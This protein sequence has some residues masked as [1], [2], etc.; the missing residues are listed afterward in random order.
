MTECGLLMPLEI[1]K[2][3]SED[4]NQ[5]DSKD[6]IPKIISRE[7]ENVSPQR[8]S[9][10][11]TTDEESDFPISTDAD[12]NVN[13]LAKEASVALPPI[14]TVKCGTLT[15][16]MVTKLFT[17]PGIHQNCILIDGETEYISP[18]E[19]T[20]RA[21]KDKQKDWKGSIRIG[22]SNL[23]TL[24]EMRS[25][26]F[27]DHPN[28]CSAK[29]QSRN[30]IT[31]K[32][33]TAD[34]SG[35]RRSST[36]KLIPQNMFSHIP[37]VFPNTSS[38]LFT[39]PKKEP[40]LPEGQ[41]TL[42]TLFK[43]PTFSRFVAISQNMKNNNFSTPSTTQTPLPMFQTS[44][45]KEESMDDMT[46]QLLQ[47]QQQQRV[48]STLLQTVPPQPSTFWN[49]ENRYQGKMEQNPQEVLAEM[50]SAGLGDNIIDMI[51]NKINNMRDKIKG[52]PNCPNILL[53]MLCSLNAADTFCNTLQAVE[54]IQAEITKEEQLLMKSQ[55][56]VHRLSS[57]YSS[58]EDEVPGRKRSLDIVDLIN[59]PQAKRPSLTTSMLEDGPEPPVVQ[60]LLTPIKPMVQIPKPIS[61]QEMLMNIAS[62]MGSTIERNQC[63]SGPANGRA[64]DSHCPIRYSILIFIFMITIIRIP[65]LFILCISKMLHLSRNVQF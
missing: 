26:D 28:Q 23:R 46:T 45:I 30:Y 5:E 22:K 29:C 65:F 24:M 13:M 8:R 64:P 48:T 60:H 32:D 6:L 56:Q 11:E 50:I 52:I 14:I 3:I 47:Q 2:E 31:P 4:R 51:V 7:T 42:G 15:A 44:N 19:F 1:K 54:S 55:S 62:S 61:P 53:K 35:R 39:V 38:S 17:C 27:H 25:L 40:Q 21:N 59:Q 63:V 12:G 58:L 37:A 49:P 9:P 18:K 16:K 57:D 43:N 34:P 10:Q 33:P 36:T 41:P 20:V